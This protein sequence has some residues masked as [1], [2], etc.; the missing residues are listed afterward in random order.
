MPSMPLPLLP[1]RR[2]LRAA[3][4]LVMALLCG[5]AQARPLQLAT[6]APIEQTGLLAKILPKVKEATGLDVK[7]VRATAAQAVAAARKGE[8]DVLLLDEAQAEPDKAAAQALS[9][10]PVPVMFSEF[11][12]VGPK[13][14]PAG[15]AGK[16]ARAALAKIDST[17]SLFIS[18]GDQ[19]VTHE[20]EQWLW[21]QA[22]AKARKGGSHR[23]CKCG[24]GSAL[25]IAATA[26]GYTLA[27][28]ATWQSFRTRGD[29]VA[30]VEGDPKLTLSYSLYL[31]NVGKL[32]KGE[33]TSAQKAEL[34]ARTRD[35]QKLAQWFTSAAGRA[36][37][38]AHL[39]H[40]QV[41]FFPPA[42]K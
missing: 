8:L 21:A 30:L 13:G 31:L 20:A 37:V 27:D 36:A 22:G 2:A 25:D 28:K 10:R 3:G 17:K 24:M 40:S 15:A 42:A 26:F 9:A 1:P 19:S 41:F 12:L 7:V 35:A 6:T 29:L 32:F 38:A 33:P 4:L 23:E 18:R 39:V 5:T 14:D 11:V 16:D 34:A